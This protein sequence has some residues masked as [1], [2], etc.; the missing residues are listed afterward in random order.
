[1]M[2]H[3]RGRA[4]EV[5]GGNYDSFW[6]EVANQ[7]WEP[8]TFRLLEHF[9]DSQHSY[10][11]VGAWVGPTVLFGSQNANI[12]YALEPDPGAF[13]ELAA[14]VE[15]NRSRLGNVHV[16]NQA[17]A[18]ISGK[19]RLDTPTR[20]GDSSATMLSRPTRESWWVDALRWDD[21]VR[22]Q[23]I[24]DCNFIKMDIEGGEYRVLPDML[25]WLEKNRPTLYLSLHPLQLYWS[26]WRIWRA[27]PALRRAYVAKQT[28]SL[29]DALA[30][31]P[32]CFSAH[33]K[34]IARDEMAAMAARQENF[35]VVFSEQSANEL[36]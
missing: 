28:A 19:L 12:T 3:V 35:A 16:L 4:F 20:A 32:H 18:P 33:G 1:M 2:I 21:L 23:N 17:L 10:V 34:L 9:I 8:E 7:T 13:A 31:Y 36:Q 5:R 11:D 27:V 30:F 25:A 14:N 24:R 6:Q 26:G 22:A 15:L 29:F